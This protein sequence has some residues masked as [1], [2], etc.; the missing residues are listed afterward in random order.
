MVLNWFSK[1]TSSGDK[2]ITPDEARRIMAQFEE[3]SS[4]ILRVPEVQPTITFNEAISYFQSD[5]PSDTTVAKGAIVRKNSSEGTLLGQIF[6]DAN[7]QLVR[8]PDGTP[9]G[10]QLVA[11]KLERK[12]NDTFE[13]KELLC[14]E[15]KSKKYMVDEFQAAIISQLSEWL[16]DLLK[17]IEVIPVMTYEDAIQYFV[18]DRP[19]DSRIEKG[20]ILRQSHPQGQFLAQMF[21]DGNHQIV[22]RSDG[23]P[24]GRKLVVKK[25]DRELQD[26]FGTK[27][28]IIVE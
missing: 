10:R 4:R 2:K 27:D 8:R 14:V 28:L 25:L 26:T 17:T 7:N 18:T 9:Y 21:L 16:Q 3:S 12:L 24:Y 15:L 22:Y 19:S 13:N 6:L 1:N 5:M 23:K 11:R 20:A